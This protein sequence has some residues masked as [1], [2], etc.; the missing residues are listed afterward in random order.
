MRLALAAVMLTVS[1]VCGCVFLFFIFLQMTMWNQA[2][3]GA[4]RLA[5]VVWF[6][7]WFF[8]FFLVENGWILT[9]VPLKAKL[10]GRSW[11]EAWGRGQG[12]ELQGRVVKLVWGRGLLGSGPL[13]AGEGTGF[14]CSTTLVCA[15]QG[16]SSLCL[17]CCVVYVICLLCHR[18]SSGLSIL[19]ALC[20]QGAHHLPWAPPL[21]SRVPVLV[22]IVPTGRFSSCVTSVKRGLVSCLASFC[23]VLLLWWCSQLCRQHFS[24]AVHFRGLWDFFLASLSF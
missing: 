24:L 12:W 1:S 17:W 2:T 6:F 21:G 20:A 14:R 19:V 10:R 4:S 11:G 3:A 23:L 8:F 18:P 22:G 15:G 16:I 13:W 9:P 7:F 5:N